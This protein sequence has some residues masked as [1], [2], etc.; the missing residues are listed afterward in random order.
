MKDT[1]NKTVVR[2]RSV[3][4]DA[5]R[6]ALIEEG[7]DV[8]ALAIASGLKPCSLSSALSK[9]FP[10]ALTR[11]K[12]EAGFQHRRPIWSNIKTLEQRRRCLEK[13]GFDPYLVG[14][15]RLRSLAKSIGA[16]FSLCADKAA[17]I[18]EVFARAAIPNT[19]T[20]PDK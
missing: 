3:E 18:R 9:D 8:R 13:F 5:V 15:R 10:D 16:D 1:V 12:V 2:L 19:T 7:L 11:F 14:V 6:I 17:M 20:K 4:T